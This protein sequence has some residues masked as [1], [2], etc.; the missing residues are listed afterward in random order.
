MLATLDVVKVMYESANNANGQVDLV[1]ITL[2]ELRRHRFEVIIKYSF[3]GV[4]SR[5]NLAK[6]Y[7][8]E[9]ERNDASL[10]ES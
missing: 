1:S 3:E 10:T 8:L 2:L 9:T 5:E 7:M 6:Y 4:R